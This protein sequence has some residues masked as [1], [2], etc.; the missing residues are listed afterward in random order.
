[1]SSIGPLR[2]PSPVSLASVSG[3]VKAVPPASVR[4]GAG[5][6]CRPYTKRTA[7]MVSAASNVAMPA[8]RVSPRYG[9]QCLAAGTGCSICR[10]CSITG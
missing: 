4:P 9:V 3:L 10:A 5:S 1:M 2:W 8:S 6:G 7:S